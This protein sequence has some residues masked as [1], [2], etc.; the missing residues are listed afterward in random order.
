LCRLNKSFTCT[1]NISSDA[2]KRF[3][4]VILRPPSTLSVTGLEI[5]TCWVSCVL[6]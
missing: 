5:L 6:E 1:N 2:I 3:S 4:S